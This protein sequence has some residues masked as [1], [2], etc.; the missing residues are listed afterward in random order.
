VVR[1]VQERHSQQFTAAHDANAPFLLQNKQASA[2]VARVRYEY[3]MV[4]SPDNRFQ[5]KLR[6]DIRL[7][8]N[9]RDVSEHADL[10]PGDPT[11]ALNRYYLYLT[12]KPRRIYFDLQFLPIF[13]IYF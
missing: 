1:K 8:R 7:M 11:R 3:R 13:C 6:V 9:R 4:Q 2:P 12:Y 5:H 10:P